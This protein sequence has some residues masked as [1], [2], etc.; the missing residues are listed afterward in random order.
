MLGN[1]P[2]PV[3]APK[4]RLRLWASRSP[5]KYSPCGI[6]PFQSWILSVSFP[7][8]QLFVGPVQKRVVSVFVPAGSGSLQPLQGLLCLSI[9]LGDLE[10]YPW[11]RA[12]EVRP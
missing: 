12:F 10:E 7:V 11:E 8:P 6:N 1:S 4:A 2:L 3:F 9:D 5:A